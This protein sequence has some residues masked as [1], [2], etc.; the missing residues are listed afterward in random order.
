[1]IHASSPGAPILQRGQ[2]TLEVVAAVPIL[3]VAALVALQLLAV[4]HTLHLADGAAEA[5]ALALSAGR[6]P[7]DAARAALPDWARDDVR[8]R[9]SGGRVSVAVAPPAPLV[10]VRRAL[11]VESSAWAQPDTGDGGD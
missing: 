6:S 3:L 4:A 9:A 11:T 5:A 7:G 8:V 2:A 10:P 1:M